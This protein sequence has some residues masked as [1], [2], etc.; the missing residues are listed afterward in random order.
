M[1]P[2]S[3]RSSSATNLSQARTPIKT[4]I[5]TP[6]T[7]NKTAGKT[8]VRRA[9]SGREKQNETRRRSSFRKSKPRKKYSAGIPRCDSPVLGEF[10]VVFAVP[11]STR[12]RR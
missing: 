3:K 6:K 5:K 10:E 7:P 9:D 4:P 12:S 8:F 11:P 2:E 1:G